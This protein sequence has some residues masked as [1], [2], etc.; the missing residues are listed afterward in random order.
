MEVIGWLVVLQCPVMTSFFNLS[1]RI[2]TLS[3]YLKM[4]IEPPS[5]RY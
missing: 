5:E 1:N 4:E 3:F 2:V